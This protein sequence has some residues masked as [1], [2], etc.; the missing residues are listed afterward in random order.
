MLTGTANRAI[1]QGAATDAEARAQQEK[2][3]EER[4][5][6]EQSQ[7]A[8]M[9]QVEKAMKEMGQAFNDML[10]PAIN[11]M[12]KILVALTTGI[13][14][15]VTAFSE[16]HIGIKLLIAGIAALALWKTRELAMEKAKAVTDKV[17]EAGSTAASLRRGY[18]P[19]M[20]LYVQIVKGLPIPDNKDKTGPKDSNKPT[21]PSDNKTDKPGS[22]D[23]S[24]PSA[25]ADDGGKK[26]GK[27]GR[28]AGGVGGL[29]GGFALDYLGEKAKAEGNEK[30]AAGLDVGSAALTGA[31]IGAFLGP[32]GAAIGGLAGGAYGAY[33]NWDTLTGKD[34][35]DTKKMADGALVSSPTNA[36]V[37]EAG[38]E[39][40]SPIQY[41]NNLQTELETL[42]KQTTD[43][44][45]YLKETAEYSRRNV[46]A[47]KSL[48][49]D[50]F[51]F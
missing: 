13:S 12:T 40:V 14:K 3:D 51:K 38:P 45:R 28:V 20:P 30:T 44:I 34:A 41:F 22:K 35:K 5:K 17:K 26:L 32:L 27:M 36:L 31:G 11:Y 50:L 16:A 9:G 7:A 33:K 42:N 46:D 29:V 21:P 15:V 18:S 10:A 49:G 19:S 2:I 37:G 8:A 47:T 39:I 23:A 25:P 43:M 6:R 1:Q 48:S 24:K 4:R